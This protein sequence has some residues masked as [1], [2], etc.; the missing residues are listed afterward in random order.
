M[1]DE[2]GAP[3]FYTGGA[4]LVPV[5]G[6]DGKIAPAGLA[7][8]AARACGHGVHS[9]RPGAAS[10]SNASELGTVYRPAELGAL[11]DS[12]RGLGIAL[13]V[14]GARFA[15]AVAALNASPAELTWKSGVDV[16]GF[17]ATKNGALAAEAIVFFDRARAAEFGHRRK[18]GG[19]L[20]SKHRFLAA[21]FDAYLE[22]GL[23][24][25]TARHANAMARRFAD[26]LVAIPGVALAHPVEANELFP[27]LPEAVIAGLERD[28]F[29]F[30]RWPGP[31]P[32]LVRLV[33]SFDTTA[34]EVDAFLASARR[35][36][37]A[38]G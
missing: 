23:W 1:T 5:E 3:E 31:D 17:G 24:L 14:D 33:C 30:Y 15:N 21:Q 28:G 34:A 10:V 29:V 6:D 27:R 35:H 32:T 36:A 9:V 25:E 19:Q 2:C 12:C 26:G 8:A 7:A 22:G 11:G 20:W 16:L 18:R 13:H 37:G 38:A 4:K